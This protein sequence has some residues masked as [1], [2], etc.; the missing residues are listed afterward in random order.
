MPWATDTRTAVGVDPQR[1]PSKSGVEDG[2]E[3]ITWLHGDATTVPLSVP[4]FANDRNVAQVFLTDK[5]WAQTLQGIHAPSA[6]VAI[7][8]FETRRPDA[9]LGRMGC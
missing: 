7:L 6:Q 3:R 1:H 5:D 2:A 8:V 4:T 9:G